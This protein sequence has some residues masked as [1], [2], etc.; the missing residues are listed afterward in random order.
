[1]LKIRQEG[2]QSYFPNIANSQHRDPEGRFLLVNGSL[3]KHMY[4]FVSYYAPNKGQVQFFQQMFQILKPLIEGT[5]ILG[6]DFN[7]AFESGLDKSN[8]MKSKLIR[9]NKGSVKIAKLI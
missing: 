8:P 5:I 2:W 6:G 4:S 7:M 1:M 3:D 9:P